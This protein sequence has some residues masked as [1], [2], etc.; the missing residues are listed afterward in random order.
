MIEGAKMRV[1][2]ER[3]DEQKVTIVG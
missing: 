1:G 2:E 3:S